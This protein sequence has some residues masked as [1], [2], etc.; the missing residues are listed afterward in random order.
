VASRVANTDIPGPSSAD[1]DLPVHIP[2]AARH[3]R[4]RA[5]EHAL[6]M[7]PYFAGSRS[8]GRRPL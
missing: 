6:G 5:S 7:T 2:V 4:W 3:E 1:A 8:R